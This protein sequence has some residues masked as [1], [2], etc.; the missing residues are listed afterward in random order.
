MRL[1]VTLVFKPLRLAA[2]LR[3][4]VVVARWTIEQDPIAFA[5]REFAAGRVMDG[6]L[7][8]WLIE[9]FAAQRRQNVVAIFSGIVG[10]LRAENGSYRCHKIDMT[11]RFVA[12]LTR[13][14]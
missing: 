13:R 14:C 11:D 12:R 5:N 6:R 7:A 8:D 3:P 1:I 9:L 4:A 10:Q 2:T